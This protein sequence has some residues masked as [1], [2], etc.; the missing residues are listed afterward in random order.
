[1]FC[2]F[3]QIIIEDGLFDPSIKYKRFASCLQK[4]NLMSVLPLLFIIFSRRLPSW[5]FEN[6]YR[7]SFCCNGQ[8][9]SQPCHFR[10]NGSVR[11][12]GA[13]FSILLPASRLSSCNNHHSSE[14]LCR[15]LEYLLFPSLHSHVYSLFFPY[16]LVFIQ[17][18][19]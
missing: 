7:K 17:D 16:F 2:A 18:I 14:L 6:S 10:R 15:G 8:I 3:C 4:T 19:P 9:P 12:S 13:M 5:V 1:M 11:R